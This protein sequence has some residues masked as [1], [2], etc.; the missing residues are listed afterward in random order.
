MHRFNTP[1]APDHTNFTDSET[2][3]SDPPGFRILFHRWDA[4]ARAAGVAHLTHMA[5][6]PGLIAAIRGKSMEH[7]PANAARDGGTAGRRAQKSPA[8]PFGNGGAFEP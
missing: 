1:C 8:F 6:K 5:A 4:A 7:A 2:L 3:L